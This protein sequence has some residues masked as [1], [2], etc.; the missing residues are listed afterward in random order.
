[1]IY[2]LLLL[3]GCLRFYLLWT[4]AMLQCRSW[5]DYP[6]IVSEASPAFVQAEYA[7]TICSTL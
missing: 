2:W 6:I 3:T 7:N 1:M 4:S 5:F